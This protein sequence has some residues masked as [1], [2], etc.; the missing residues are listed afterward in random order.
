ML[1]DPV[2]RAFGSRSDSQDVLRKIKEV[3]HLQQE[4]YHDHL[5]VEI[6]LD[7]FVQDRST[8]VANFSKFELTRS[9]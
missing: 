2:Q 1:L 7:K 9:M 5:N 8:L 3:R 4:I 6:D